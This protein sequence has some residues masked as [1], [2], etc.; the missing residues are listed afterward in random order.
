MHCGT[1]PKRPAKRP[2]KAG[3][4]R[5]PVPANDRFWRQSENSAAR[6]QRASN[7]KFR[8]ASSWTGTAILLELRRWQVPSTES[9]R[10]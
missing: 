10:F 2:E 6:G 9:N 4:G 5:S 8:E 3:D 7:W 1:Q